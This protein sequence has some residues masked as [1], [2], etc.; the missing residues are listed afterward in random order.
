MTLEI[1]F[2]DLHCKFQ[3]IQPKTKRLCSLN[4]GDFVQNELKY[5][6]GLLSQ[7]IKCAINGTLSKCH[8]RTLVSIR[9]YQSLL[10]DTRGN[11]PHIVIKLS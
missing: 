9:A 1:V 11:K 3:K 6:L 5:K 7:L 10:F 4:V 2:N 8:I